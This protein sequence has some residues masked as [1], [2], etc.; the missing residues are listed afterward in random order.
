MAID[1]IVSTIGSGQP[2]LQKMS[3]AHE[4]ERVHRELSLEL[5][6]SPVNPAFIQM[7]TPPLNSYNHFFFFFFLKSTRSFFRKLFQDRGH[8]FR[9][10]DR[11]IAGKELFFYPFSLHSSLKSLFKLVTRTALDS[12]CNIKDGAY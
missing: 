1:T 8:S 2:K 3:S 5:K 10:T 7:L 12:E 4:M 9:Y 11:P 6:E